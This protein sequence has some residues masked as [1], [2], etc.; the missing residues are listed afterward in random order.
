MKLLG[1]SLKSLFKK[2]ST[3]KYPKERPE[4]P[5]G[6]R[7]KLEHDKEKCIYCGLCAKY[8]PSSAIT[9]DTKNKTWTHDLGRC[10]FCAQCEEIC[11]EMPKRNA[12]KMTTEF[13]LA[14]MK[15]KRFIRTHKKP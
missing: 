11:R 14:E 5:E 10:L 8:C 2:P 7:G 12:I 13:E 9:V 1:E 6:L 4:V 3:L 15:K